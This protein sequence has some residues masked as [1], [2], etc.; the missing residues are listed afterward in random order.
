LDVDFIAR[1]TIEDL[2]IKQDK[3]DAV[4]AV[5]IRTRIDGSLLGKV[6]NPYTN[7]ECSIRTKI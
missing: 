5:S 4:L 1:E 7:G 6:A 2:S 3:T